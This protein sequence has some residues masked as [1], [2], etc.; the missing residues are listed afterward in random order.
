MA[1]QSGRNR[2]L[3]DIYY[4][5]SRSG[6]HGSCWR[7]WFTS[8]VSSFI[9]LVASLMCIQHNVLTFSRI[10]DLCGSSVSFAPVRQVLCHCTRLRTLNLSSCRALPR[11]IKRLYDGVTQ[12]SS[13][14]AAIQAGRFDDNNDQ[15]D[16]WWNNTKQTHRPA[17]ILAVSKS[18]PFFNLFYISRWYRPFHF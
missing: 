15:G 12:L 16:E 11:G 17:S 14:R 10:L 3:L 13:L 18:L 7:R 1:S 5:S 4:W 8:Q 9:L 2:S 6:S